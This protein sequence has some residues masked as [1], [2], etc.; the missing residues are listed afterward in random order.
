MSKWPESTEWHDGERKEFRFDN[1]YIISLVR[2]TGSYGWRDRLWELA[3]IDGD[4]Q[5]FVDPPIDILNEYPKADPGVYGFLND[6]EADRIIQA[7]E[8]LCR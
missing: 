5:E 7:V 3:I 8:K 4:T 1:G 6:P 2:F